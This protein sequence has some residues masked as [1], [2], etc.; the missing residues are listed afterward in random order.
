VSAL[1]YEIEKLTK[2]NQEYEDAASKSN[3]DR[4]DQ[5]TKSLEDVV[6]R[7]GSIEQEQ[8][9][10]IKAET[11][12]SETPKTC[13]NELDIKKKGVEIMMTKTT[14]NSNIKDTSSS[15]HNNIFKCDQCNFTSSTRI[16]LNKHTNTKHA[17]NDSGNECS[18]CEDSFSSAKELKKH[19]D[20]HIE[21]IESLYIASLTKGHDLF[22]CN[23]FSF[24]SGHKDSIREHLITHVNPQN[25]D[26][27]VTV[28]AKKR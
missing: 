27:S 12:S 14:V 5:L 1:K 6:K 9:E 2:R 16:T 3:S 13:I 17:E 19:I 18:L 10:Q 8:I 25:E 21:E 28:V 24:E 11:N 7:L 23:L 26:Y 4:F 15:N 22:E 20:E